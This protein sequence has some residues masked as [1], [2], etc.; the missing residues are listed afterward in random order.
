MTAEQVTT[1]ITGIF[2]MDNRLVNG[3]V[4]RRLFGPTTVFNDWNIECYGSLPG[5]R[6]VA[7]LRAFFMEPMTGIGPPTRPRK[8]QPSSREC[9]GTFA[10]RQFVVK[11]VADR[12]KILV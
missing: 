10:I 12:A 1:S 8:H 6:S 3:T 11:P 9:C 2:E 4:L 5:H 7:I